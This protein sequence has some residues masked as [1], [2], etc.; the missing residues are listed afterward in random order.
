MNIPENKQIATLNKHEGCHVKRKM[1]LNNYTFTMV[2]LMVVIAIILILAML[3][4]PALNKTREMANRIY[5]ANNIRGVLSGGLLAYSNDY[6]DW[7]L[8]G[9]YAT[10]GGT[11]KVYYTLIL[12]KSTSSRSLGYLPWIYHVG[13]AYGIMKCPS[14]FQSCGSEPGINFGL[15]IHTTIRNLKY[16]ATH[17]LFKI[18]SPQVPSRTLYIA[19]CQ[20]FGTITIE[21]AMLEKA[22][23]RRHNNTTNAGFC[24]GHVQNLTKEQ[25]PWHGNSTVDKVLSPWSG[26]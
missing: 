9:K 16:D 19:D 11:D 20:V 14:E 10:Y 24:D 8:Y 6:N 1:N 15:G 18:N 17:A 26:M 12:G 4:L 7:T 5:C 2:E 25:L 3:L 23:S 21:S 13:M 22:P